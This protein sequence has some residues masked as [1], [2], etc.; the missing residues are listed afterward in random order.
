MIYPYAECALGLHQSPVN[1]EGE[2]NA[3][4]SNTLEV[5]YADDTPDFFNSGHA[6]QVN[7]S[8][9][10]KGR[11]TIGNDLYPLIQYHFHAPSEHQIGVKTFPAELHLV[12]IREDGKIAVLG[13]L[14][15]EGEANPAFQTILDKVSHHSGVLNSDTGIV[16]NPKSLL[17]DDLSHFD[18]YA[19]SLTTPPC[20]EGVNWFVFAEPVTISS[21]QLEQLKGFFPDLYDGSLD[22]YTNGNAR[23]TQDLN[24]R[25]VTGKIRKNFSLRDF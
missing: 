21:D 10:Y 18:T 3:K 17:P 20:S 6:V 8:D 22:G 19:G 12:H 2:K 5:H 13:V 14:L 11:L 25:V 1:L 4:K 15:E 7:S 24:G 16:I 9:N 23:F